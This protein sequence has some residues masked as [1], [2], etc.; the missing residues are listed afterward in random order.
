MPFQPDFQSYAFQAPA[1]RPALSRLKF[2]HPDVV[3]FR[4]AAGTSALRR[5]GGGRDRWPPPRLVRGWRGRRGASRARARPPGG[6]V[7]SCRTPLN[8]AH[9]PLAV[10]R[11]RA[12]GGGE[13]RRPELVSPRLATCATPS[14][15]S[16][17]SLNLDHFV[18]CT[19]H[20]IVPSCQHSTCP[21]IQSTRCLARDA[22]SRFS[23]QY[24]PF[25]SGGRSSHIA[26][27]PPS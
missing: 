12:L 10:A 22:P 14:G 13:L 18:S 25:R 20:R 21:C 24:T 19:V 16:V 27:F 11:A 3:L 8:S 9:W 7:G 17:P 6:G 26:R 4:N 5:G 15:D 23:R 1:S 2:L